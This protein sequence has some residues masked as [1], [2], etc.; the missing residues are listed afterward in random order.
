[1]NT[2]TKQELRDKKDAADNMNKILRRKIHKM[3]EWSRENGG[4]EDI[5]KREI[6]KLNPDHCFDESDKFKFKRETRRR[7]NFLCCF[8][9]KNILDISLDETLHHKIP[10]RYGGDDSQ[11]NQITICKYCHRLLEELIGYVEKEAL[12][13]NDSPKP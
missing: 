13:L 11:D 7:D 4:R 12:E 6:L 8:C 1:M 3:K 9:K 10:R 2:E 5:L